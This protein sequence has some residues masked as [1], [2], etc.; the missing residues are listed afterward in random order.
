MPARFPLLLPLLL[1]LAVL[2]APVAR[3]DTM[4]TFP[5]DGSGSQSLSGDTL[6]VT[7]SG[8]TLG[9]IAFDAIL[10]VL[11][12][13]TLNQISSGLGVEG[14]SNPINDGE[15]LSFSVAVANESGGHVAFAGFN[16]LDFSFFGA[17]GEQA[18]CSSDASLDTADDNF[19]VGEGE[20]DD[21]LDLSAFAPLAFTLF[22]QDAGGTVSFRV[23]AIDA[24]FEECDPV[25]EPGTA[26]LVGAAL[27]LGLRRVRRRS[28]ASRRDRAQIPPPVPGGA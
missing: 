5:L 17:E 15:W 20:D 24:R 26:L 4:S 11:G 14:G 3:A 27:A 23:D 10:T 12:S 28:A 13:G 2:W 16:S 6:V 8:L 18:V 9:S 19:L 7:L 1:A 22:G 25:P 21:P